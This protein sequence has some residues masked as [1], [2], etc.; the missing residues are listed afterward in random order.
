MTIFA[1]VLI[2]LALYGLLALVHPA[3][4]RV[5]PRGERFGGLVDARTDKTLGWLP[6]ELRKQDQLM[7]RI[8]AAG[9]TT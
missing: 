7:R 8:L 6:P 3:V 2:L 9:A 1:I 4:H 5:Q